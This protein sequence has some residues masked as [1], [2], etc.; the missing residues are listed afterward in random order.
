MKKGTFECVQKFVKLS[1]NKTIG[2][3]NEAIKYKELEIN[4]ET[5]T[6][7]DKYKQ[8]FIAYDI[9]RARPKVNKSHSMVM[10]LSMNAGN[11]Y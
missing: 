1:I 5:T 11:N 3:V 4:N 8:T 6:F 10:Y 7:V 9:K 2:H